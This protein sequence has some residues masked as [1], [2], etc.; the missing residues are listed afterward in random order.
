M[1]TSAYPTL[2]SPPG[3]GKR[4]YLYEKSAVEEGRPVKF[5]CFEVRPDSYHGK[6]ECDRSLGCTPEKIVIT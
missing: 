4:I 5:C 6:R 3:G 2:P 1:A